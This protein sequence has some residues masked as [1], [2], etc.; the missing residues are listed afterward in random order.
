MI[1]D[2]SG[3]SISPAINFLCTPTF[4]YSASLVDSSPLPSFISEDINSPILTINS[5]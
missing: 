3:F 5:M 4:T 2:L 1:I